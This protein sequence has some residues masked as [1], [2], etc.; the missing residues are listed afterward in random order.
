MNIKYKGDAEMKKKLFSV[1]SII[2]TLVT[3]LTA[4]SGITAFAAETIHIDEAP[5]FKSI[6]A[7]CTSVTIKWE[8]HDD[9]ELQFLVYRSNTGKAGTWKKLAT[10]KAGATSYTDK[11]VAPNKTYVYTVKAYYKEKDGTTYVSD[12][13]G[14]HTVKTVLAKPSFSLCGNG[15]KG[16][17]MQ[18]DKRSDAT[19]FI[20]YTSTTGKS[21]S[22][23]R[24]KTV[25]SNA[26]GSFTHTAVEIGKTYYY[27]IKV[28]KTIGESTYTSVS[29]S[30]KMVIMDVAVPQNLVATAKSDGIYLTFD[31]VP[32]TAGYYIYKSTTGKAKT[33]TK[34]ATTT[35]NNKT[36]YVDTDVEEGKVYYYTVKSYKT[37]SGKTKASDPIKAVKVINYPT[38]PEAEFEPAEITFKDYYE[39][40]TVKLNLKGM[41]ADDLRLFIDGTEITDLLV[42]NDEAYEEFLK[43]TKF[44]YSVDEDKS[45]DTAV[46]FVISRVAPGTGVMKVQHADHK[47]ISAEIKVNCPE[48]DFDKDVETIVLNAEAGFEAI[49]NAADLL[50]DAKAAT[51]KRDE[52]IKNAKKQ[53]TGA[54]S[55]LENAKLLLEKYESQYSKY[56]AYKS[57]VKNVNDS[58]NA[59]N[60]ALAL[61]SDT[62]VT[63]SDIANAI[64]ELDDLVDDL[65]TEI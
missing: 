22:W 17:V 3:L 23:K 28:F 62:T 64:R 25:N 10:T 12:M 21:G 42:K 61:I 37:V 2:M 34:I 27:C 19:G 4:F 15:G 52:L 26:A 9:D 7:T 60:T 5:K 14:K 43:K 45:T 46:V 40:I 50:E 56:D 55:S 38:L 16:V 39:E 20:I 59:A 18:W 35:S 48:L 1:I 54:K 51:D 6:S 63:D 31:K 41:T 58:L 24:I 53:L 30:Y 49:E 57:D 47:E 32:G 36:G 11:T 8:E 13:S 44:V 65:L 29:K 33:W